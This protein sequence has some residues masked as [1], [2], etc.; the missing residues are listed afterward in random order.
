MAENQDTLVGTVVGDRY[1]LLSLL[2]R[3]GMASVYR[4]HDRS[5][6]RGV[7]V[8]IFAATEVDQNA[9]RRESGE[10]RLLASLNHYA[11]VTLFDAAV[12]AAATD[13]AY[14]VMEL[15][16]GPTLGER[17][18][19]GPVEQSDVALMLH[20]LADA[21]HVVHERGAVHRDIKP[22]NILLGPS[23]SPRVGF[24]AKLSDFGIA[25]V[26]D[27]TR[28]T[29]PGTIVGTA[30]YVSPEQAM[31][32]APGPQSDVYSL[33]LVVLESLTGVRAFPGSMVE[34]LSARLVGDPVIPASLG[35]GWGALLTRM[36]AREPGDRPTALEVADAARDLERTLHAP[37]TAPDLD[38]T[39]AL[40][41][42]AA[43]EATEA[44]PGTEA[45]APTRAMPDPTR[46][47]PGTEAL[48]PTRAYPAATLAGDA[49]TERFAAPPQHPAPTESPAGGR[50][51]PRRVYVAL[52][53]IVLIVAALVIGLAIVPPATEQPTDVP[54]LSENSGDL[55]AHL[56]QLLGSVTP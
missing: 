51:R 32:T 7:A 56:D 31:G 8:K 52:A 33:G 20:D 16:E 3:G 54:T 30:A 37:T 23:A 25:Y 22:A 18:S 46:A 19:A 15:V 2:G 40:D 4:A 28:L 41:D 26:V 43:S 17:I 49:P 45:P 11:L 1:E 9:M 24:R 6:G 13:R 44:M 39:L 55:G 48:A 29:T 50:R 42:S 34:S 27:S 38:A 47:M 21:L 5:L 35:A 10:I 53:G 14:F 36:T 12:D